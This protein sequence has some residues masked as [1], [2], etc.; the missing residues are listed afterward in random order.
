LR[1]GDQEVGLVQGPMFGTELAKARVTMLMTEA[2]HDGRRRRARRERGRRGSLRLAVG[3]RLVTM[4][5]RLLGER[6]EAR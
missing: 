3:M 1:E 6:V 2:L 4:G 5:S